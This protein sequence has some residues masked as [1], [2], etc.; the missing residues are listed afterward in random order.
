MGCPL[1][2]RCGWGARAR[3]PPGMAGGRS[4]PPPGS[5]EG[6]GSSRKGCWRRGWAVSVLYATGSWA[7]AEVSCAHR[8]Y[9]E[10]GSRAGL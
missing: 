7:V 5:G 3:L 6:G 2:S 4:L 9:G 10:V 1:L 8:M